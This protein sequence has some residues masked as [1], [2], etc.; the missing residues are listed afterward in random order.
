MKK[1]FLTVRFLGLILLLN[2][3]FLGLILILNVRFLGLILLLRLR[4][5]IL[6]QENKMPHLRISLLNDMVFF[7][8]I[9][10]NFLKMQAFMSCFE[11]QYGLKVARL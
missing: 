7:A 2:V 3:R 1:L 6:L 5:N 11:T 9:K 10:Q 4:K 8:Y